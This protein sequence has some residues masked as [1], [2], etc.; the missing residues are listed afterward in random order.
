M[1]RIRSTHPGQWTSGDFLECSPL[2]R[3]LALALRNVADDHGAF[4]WKPTTLK[5]ECL[6]GDN[7]EIASLLEELIRN[8]QIVKYAIDGK[9][10]GLIK[11]FTQ[12]QRPKKPK[13]LHPVPPEFS[14]S[15][16]LVPDEDHTEPEIPPQRKEVGGRRED[17]KENIPTPAKVQARCSDDF[18][19]LKKVYPRR[20]G[21]YGWKAAERKFNSLVKTGVD[22]KIIIAAATRLCETLK[23]R[24]GTEFIPMPT[25]WLNSE[26]FV[27]SAVVAFEAEKPIDWDVV[28][29]D[30]K[31]W[32][33]WSRW[34]GPDLDS[35]ECRAPKEMLAK[36]GLLR[37]ETSHSAPIIP[38]PQSM[39]GNA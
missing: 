20:N 11:D 21:N 2:A 13:Y 32:G 36:H 38:R 3:L 8:S 26:D 14:T 35:P 34:A 33:R 5:A 16:E 31:R 24:I 18:E 29:T 37:A 28:L 6:P 22:P 30:F 9:E 19:N 17:V 23:S 4:R 39:Q 7:C 15:T 10:Y 25:S 27:E 12:W 1:A